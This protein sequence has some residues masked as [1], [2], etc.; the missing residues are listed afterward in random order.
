MTSATLRILLVEDNRAHA[1]L[2]QRNIRTT[3]TPPDV[4]HVMDGEE[5]LRYLEWACVRNR[6]PDVVL[7]DLRLPKLDG[8][9]VLLRIRENESLG[10]L[11]VVVLSTSDRE[12]DVKY[13]YECGAADYLVKPFNSQKLTQIIDTLHS[14]WDERSVDEQT[15]AESPIDVLLVEDDESHIRLIR[16]AFASSNEQV[17]LRCVR[18]LMELRTQILCQRP[19]IVILDYLLP[20]GRGVDFLCAHS[21]RPLLPTVM[22]TGYAD[23]QV[24]GE[25]MRAGVNDCVRKSKDGFAT[26]PS[27][28]RRVLD[29]VAT[30]ATRDTSSGGQ[31][32]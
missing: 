9:S 27:V 29:S 16:R 19:D 10:G 20:D 3:P 13:A 1:L 5:A 30:R 7:L 4:H 12:A 31:A 6:L 32:F 21:K 24:I 26:L 11:P 8:F 23:E 2:V 22:I 18:S 25:A 14:A 15:S 28:V 17:R